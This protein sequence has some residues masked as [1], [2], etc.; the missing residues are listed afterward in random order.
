[1][2]AESQ[3]AKVKSVVYPYFGSEIFRVM[4]DSMAPGLPGRS[5]EDTQ[6]GWINDG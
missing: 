6:L 3:W 4:S 1:M 2:A 5:E